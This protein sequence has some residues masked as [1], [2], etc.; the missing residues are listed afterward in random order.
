[1]FVAD[2]DNSCNQVVNLQY[3]RTIDFMTKISPS[4][5]LHTI[6]RELRGAVLVCFVWGDK[7]RVYS[8]VIRTE[9][10]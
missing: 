7:Q 5:I 3:Y 6:S 8:F 1:V 2:M 4:M 9:K 10:R